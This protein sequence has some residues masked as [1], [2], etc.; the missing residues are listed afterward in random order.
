MK[1]RAN[2]F[3]G[4][5]ILAISAIEPVTHLYL[6][7]HVPKE[8]VFTGLH[9]PDDSF[10]M[11]SLPIFR[12]GFYSPYLS[13]QH[14]KGP[15]DPAIYSLP[16]YWLYGV[17]GQVGYWLGLG[18]FMTLGW[19]NGLFGA[20]YLWA[21]Y[22]FLVQCVPALAN[23]AFVLFAIGGGLGG[24]LY[25]LTYLCGAQAHPGFEAWFHRFARYELIEGPFLSPIL[26]Q[27]RLYYMAAL[28]L[29]FWT[30][31][32]ALR[33]QDEP[34]W[35]RQIGP[36]FG[37]F[38]TSYLHIRIGPLFW[39]IFVLFQVARH[40]P[41]RDTFWRAALYAVPVLAAGILVGLQYRLNPAST[42]NIGQLLRRSMW[43][44]SF[45]T[46]ACW[47]LL[48][49]APAALPALR[50]VEGGPR[51]IAWPA[52]GYL[53]A[54]LAL[55]VLHQ[56]YYGNW[57]GGGDAAAAIAVSDVALC[58]AV[59]GL[60]L[61]IRNKR[62]LGGRVDGVDMVDGM[63]GMDRVDKDSLL[64]GFLLWFLALTA[65]AV[66]AFG[67][68]WF[69]R[70]M[71]ERCMV[72][73]GVPLSVL[74]ACGLREWGAKHRRVGHALWGLLI[75][76]GLCSAVVSVLVFQ[77]PLGHGPGRGTFQWT[78]SEYMTRAEANVISMIGEGVVLAPASEPPLYSDLIVNV[79]PG[80]TT[81]L[82]QATLS[83]GDT[84]VL[85]MNSAIQHWF[86]AEAGEQD[87]R[88]FVDRWCV[89][90]VFCPEARPVSPEVLE[91]LRGTAW[92]KSIAQE[93]GASLFEVEGGGGQ[94]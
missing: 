14:A 76:S 93:G 19:A 54:F 52:A 10:L 31:A 90:Y 15:C 2:L 33:R 40:A 36:L 91:Q 18:E 87:R 62:L 68:G 22:R 23:R 75:V 32:A 67:Q 92:L 47:Y 45:L 53:T 38:L 63:D 46:A 74:A 78:H 6:Q 7:Y 8:A 70:F 55:Y 73:L 35:K 25:L 24:P 83:L 69:L 27:Y 1:P 89:R 58:G 81:M 86:S 39:G 28:A 21:V 61:A 57:L 77:G 42:E 84:N 56:T 82:G 85:E 48:A 88:A 59:V 72:L 65:V 66:S 13:C 12:N 80:A 30:L 20:L 5:L 51:W 37:F 17:V 9:I 60:V 50:R 11:P 79:R 94:P 4:F 3:I 71:P 44:G 26:L 34:D 29:G 41:A 43:M 64:P 49:A 16:H